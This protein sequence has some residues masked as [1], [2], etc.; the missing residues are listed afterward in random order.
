[1]TS[2]ARSRPA[3][4]VR[5]CGTGSKTRTSSGAAHRAPRRSA[6]MPIAVSSFGASARSAASNTN[7]G[8]PAALALGELRLA[9]KP[10]KSWRTSAANSGW[11]RIARL[12]QHFARPLAPAGAPGDL[13]QHREQAL[14]RAV[15]G[16]DQRA[17]GVQHADQRERREVVALGEQLRADQD[18]AFAAPDAFQRARELAAAPRAV[19]VD[20]HDARAGKA[21]GQRLLDA[22][23]AAPHRLQVDV[24]AGRA[25]ARDRALRRRSDGSA[26]CRS[27]WRAAPCRAVQRSQPAVQPQ[28]SQASTGA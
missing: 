19:A 22:L 2:C 4:R 24:A 7:G 27:R 3:R 12:D 25:G 6:G 17:V 10:A 28:A 21:R 16:G 5:R 1:M 11:P 8:K 26:G 15:V 9:A 23:R 20:A 13:R 14:G 18:V